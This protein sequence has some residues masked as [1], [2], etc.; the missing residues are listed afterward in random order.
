MEIESICLHLLFPR[1]PWRKSPV[2]PKVLVILEKSTCQKTE[3]PISAKT[4]GAG[5][6]AGHGA[7][8]PQ[9]PEQLPGG[10][11]GWF[12]SQDHSLETQGLLFPRLG[13]CRQS[14]S[15]L[16]TRSSQCRGGELGQAG[17]LLFQLPPHW[18]PAM[19]LQAVHLGRPKSL[20]HLEHGGSDSIYPT[21]VFGD[22]MR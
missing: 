10:D 21:E 14:Q 13:G 12:L 11:V 3:G 18:V 16:P 4:A 6:R 1:R 19:W 7:L 15:C 20:F 17:G 8:G 5:L 9:L 2:S 22:P